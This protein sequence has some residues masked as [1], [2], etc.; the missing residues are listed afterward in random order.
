MDLFSSQRE[1]T[2]KGQTGKRTNLK[3][4]ALWV[5]FFPFF[6]NLEEI[7][8]DKDQV[9]WKNRFFEVIKIQSLNQEEAEKY[10][11]QV[12]DKIDSYL[13]KNKDE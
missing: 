13:K 4:S 11:S 2:K 5:K 1:N 10:W 9:W 3:A 7:G 12:W 8:K 6:C